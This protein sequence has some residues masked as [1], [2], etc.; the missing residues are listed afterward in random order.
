MNHETAPGAGNG[1]GDLKQV[2]E[3]LQAL[4]ARWGDGWVIGH[5]GRGW[6]AARRS[7]AGSG[8]LRAAS[9]AELA[10]LLDAAAGAAS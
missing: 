4:R 6:H 2:S 1:A 5:D 8:I 7:P 3:A 10:A 9:P